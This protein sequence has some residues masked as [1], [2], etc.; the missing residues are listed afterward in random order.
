MVPAATYI[1]QS[2]NFLARLFEETVTFRS[3]PPPPPAPAAEAGA[4]AEGAGGLE[5]HGA[6]T[7]SSCYEGELDYRLFLDFAMAV[8]AL[9][10]APPPAP[11][12]PGAEA[13]VS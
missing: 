11:L 3:S 8:E 1:K 5:C 9:A 6:A 7:A 13:P 12:G 10:E 4:G 2:R